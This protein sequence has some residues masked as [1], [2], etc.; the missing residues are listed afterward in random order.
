MATTT[1]TAMRDP[2]YTC[3]LHRSSRQHQI[4]NPLREARAQTCI[5]M[6]TSWVPRMGTLIPLP[7]VGRKLS[8]RGILWSALLGG[9][10]P[11]PGRVP[12]TGGGRY[13]NSAL[14]DPQ[15]GL[16][17]RRCC[18]RVKPVVSGVGWSD[19]NPAF[20]NV[21]QESR[22]CTRCF[23]PRKMVTLR[24]IKGDEHQQEDATPLMLTGEERRDG[25]PEPRSWCHRDVPAAAKDATRCRGRP[26]ASPLL[27]HP[28]SRWWNRAGSLGGCHSSPGKGEQGWL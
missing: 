12:P 5:L 28:V 23:K 22:N 14:L 6:D 21:S 16:S 17:K 27:H 1:A 26:S 25:A 24:L 2:S 4:L 11:S 8:K 19:L 10:T 18:L 20:A 7:L 3:D 15:G 13:C 9:R